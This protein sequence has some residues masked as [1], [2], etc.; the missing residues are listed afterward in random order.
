MKT[1][2]FAILVAAGNAVQLRDISAVGGQLN[3]ATT[4]AD[5][6]G[7]NDNCTIMGV[8]TEGCGNDDNY[9]DSYAEGSTS[10]QAVSHGTVV[11]GNSAVESYSYVESEN[12]DAEAST[13]ASASQTGAQSARRGEPAS[14]DK[15]WNLIPGEP[16]EAAVLQ[17]LEVD[18]EGSTETEAYHYSEAEAQGDG[19]ASVG[20]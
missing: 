14:Y 8:N 17:G 9:A 19:M 12:D 15:D 3:V 10:G 4:S 1:S 20:W 7:G 5:V 13:E 2:L 18:A 16:E 11:M 6:N